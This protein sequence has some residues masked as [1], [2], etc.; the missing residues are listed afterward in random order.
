MNHQPAAN[1]FKGLAEFLRP[2]RR[3]LALLRGVADVID[4]DGGWMTVSH[5]EA[6][7]EF[8]S[9]SQDRVYWTSIDKAFGLSRLQEVAAIAQAR[10]RKRVFIWIVPAIDTGADRCA[11]RELEAAGL[12]RWPHV[13]YLTLA[14]AAQ[15][16]Q[17]ERPTGV[18]ARALLDPDEIERVLNSIEP[19]YSPAGVSA[20][21]EI[22]AR[23]VGE[24][25]AA[26]CGD[27]PIS[28]AFL[29]VRN[30]WA[31]LSSAGTD[32]AHRNKGGQTALICAR[33]SDA[34]T[35][36]ATCAISETNTV[37]AASLRNLVRCGFTPVIKWNVWKWDDPLAASSTH[38]PS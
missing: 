25:Y 7:G 20:A 30:E 23:G 35:R 27:T 4:L 26:F 28:A 16:M 36:G 24:L 10:R 38:S 12:V 13:E 18:H 22:A 37:A 34:A 1:I 15:P 11:E 2:L 3:D 5:D 21:R 29:H 31:Y 9:S 33:V 32:P 8:P 17:P 6:T 19:W 14:R